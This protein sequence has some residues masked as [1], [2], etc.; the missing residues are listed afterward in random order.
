MTKEWEKGN[1]VLVSRKCHQGQGWSTYQ[2]EMRSGP[3][4]AGTAKRQTYFHVGNIHSGKAKS[5]PSV[6]RTEKKIRDV[7]N[8]TASNASSVNVT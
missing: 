1:A 3:S 8:L 5:S 2:C 7:P 6:T 4:W